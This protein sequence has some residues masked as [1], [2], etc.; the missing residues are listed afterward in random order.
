M[1]KVKVSLQRGPKVR[2]KGERRAM[3]QT[4]PRE[5]K[6]EGNRKDKEAY[7]PSFLMEFFSLIPLLF[8]LRTY[9]PQPSVLIE[10]LPLPSFV[11]IG[12]YPRIRC[13]Y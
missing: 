3:E 5:R 12:P 6:E 11:F 10:N 13:F 8:S 1:V 7:T 2:R 9:P 4:P